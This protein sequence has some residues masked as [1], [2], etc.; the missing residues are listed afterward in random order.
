[1]FRESLKENMKASIGA[2]SM[3]LFR[4]KLEAGRKAVFVSQMVIEDTKM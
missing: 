1:M 3:D 2:S 4:H